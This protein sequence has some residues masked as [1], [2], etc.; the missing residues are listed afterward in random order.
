MPRAEPARI[1]VIKPGWLTTVQD[2]GRYG[3]QQYGVPV[4]GA[5]DRRSFIIANR[6]VGNRD[7][8]AGLEITVN[9]P[10]LL[11]EQNAII[12][13]TGGELGPSVNGI[14]I[15][16]WTSVWIERGSRLTFG[17]R[18]AGARG[19]LAIAGGIDVPIVLG[20]RS[21]HTYSRTGG[22][23]GR[24]LVQGDVLM[25]G[26][27]PPR[28]RATI[29]RALPER[30]HPVYSTVTTLRILPGPQGFAFAQH[31]L[32]RLTSRPYR[33][34]TQ[35]DRMGYRLD[36]P[37]VTHTEAEEWISD[38]TAMGAL[39]VPADGQPILL[40][41]DRHTTGGYPKIAVVISADLHLAA[42]LLPG[43]TIEFKTTTLPEAQVLMKAEW[44]E[45]DRVLPLYRGLP[46]KNG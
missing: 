9:G 5:M 42:Q 44:M 1:T 21:T 46:A 29:G 40:M 27:P 4:S 39:Q 43:E 3:Y 19:Y 11:F 45:I 7:N 36:G 14:G 24:A 30:L 10:E 32:A 18:R 6:L 20:S 41:A 8:D 22:M 35:S 31:A 17:A 16:R 26:T 2:L 38:G 34:S 37:K 12:A 28:T 25:G 33:L 13:I 23:Q 15:P